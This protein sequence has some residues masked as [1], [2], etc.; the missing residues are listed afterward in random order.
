ML[1]TR[2]RASAIGAVVVMLVASVGVQVSA[3]GSP[4]PTPVEPPTRPAVT[5]PVFPLITPLPVVTNCRVEPRLFHSLKTGWID[6]CRGHLGYAPGTL[7]CYNFTDQV[8]T[9]FLPATQRWTESRQ[10]SPP[11][12]FPCPDAPEPPSCP[13]LGP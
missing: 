11:V 10:E 12:V 13:R 4:T 6:Y 3:A 8:C 5:T 7:D 1:R 2:M 9:V